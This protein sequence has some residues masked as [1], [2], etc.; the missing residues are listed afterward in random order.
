[1]YIEDVSKNHPGGLKGRK[2]KPKIVYHHANTEKPERCFVHL[3][4]LY[5]SHCP[6]NRPDNAYYLK[7]LQKPLTD[8]CWYT[9]QPV[10][11]YK[12]EGSIKRMCS[13]AGIPG[14]RTNHSLRAT[15]ATRLH[16]SG[17]VQE[18]EIMERTGH[19]STEAVRSYKRT[20]TE[21]LEQVSD[22]LN[23]G[24]TQKRS[25]LNN[26]RLEVDRNDLMES[27]SRCVSNSLSLE[28]T[29]PGRAPIFNISSC[30]SIIINNYQ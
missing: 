15:A 5:N 29:V 4:K 9:N 11:H 3:Y 30:P 25:C 21:Q 27:N 23:N 2:I 16:Q 8:D 24:S 17:C 7:P 22:I 13:E 1:M 26:T 6:L 20:S 12:L 14:Y 10:G 18:Q 19:R 28:Y